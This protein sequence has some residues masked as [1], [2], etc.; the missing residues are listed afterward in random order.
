LLPLA[1]ELRAVLLPP[2]RSSGPTCRC[3]SLCCYHLLLAPCMCCCCCCSCEH[4]AGTCV[5]TMLVSALF[6]ESRFAGGVCPPLQQV[7]HHVCSPLTHVGVVAADALCT[8]ILQ[9][10][11]AP[12]LLGACTRRAER[13]PTWR[14][15][16][17]SR[18]C[19]T[20]VCT[21]CDPL[22]ARTQGRAR[23][24]VRACTSVFCVTS[25]RTAASAGAS[26]ARG[27]RAPNS[28]KC[29]PA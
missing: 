17:T 20:S 28:V 15:A 12:D 14:C 5:A 1:H 10:A 26:A 4:Q 16:R 13:D 23:P 7:P 8:L 19:A 9:E 11:P 18:V 24:N 22:G 25:V 21:S 27:S 29:A 6:S 2:V 3:Q